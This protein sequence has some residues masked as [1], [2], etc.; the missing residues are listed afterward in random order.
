MK[1]YNAENVKI[2]EKEVEKEK[3]EGRKKEAVNLLHIRTQ[4]RRER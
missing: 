1:I 4:K 3:E 2:K